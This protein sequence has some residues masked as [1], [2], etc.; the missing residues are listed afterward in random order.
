[1]IIYSSNKL[2]RF[3]KSFFN[4]RKLNWILDININTS[5]MSTEA[6]SPQL[7]TDLN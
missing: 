3:H 2:S 6:Y 7:M 5:F 4:F 1:M